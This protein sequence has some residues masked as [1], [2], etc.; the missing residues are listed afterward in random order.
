MLHY[1]DRFIKS[2]FAQ[3][4]LTDSRSVFSTAPGT[5]HRM[6]VSTEPNDSILASQLRHSGT[7]R[8]DS[9]T[10]LLA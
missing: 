8:E 6:R 3:R 7:L 2:Y 9:H 4:A 10:T 1:I 5:Y